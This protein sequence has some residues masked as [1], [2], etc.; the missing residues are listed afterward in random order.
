MYVRL[1]ASVVLNTPKTTEIAH[2]IAFALL[3]SWKGIDGSFGTNGLS[4]RDDM[5]IFMRKEDIF[6][7]KSGKWIYSFF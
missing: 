3:L 5:L 6:D 4:F 2:R 1:N 7:R